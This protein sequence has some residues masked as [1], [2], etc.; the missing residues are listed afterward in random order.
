MFEEKTIEQKETTKI[1]QDWKGN[2]CEIN[3]QIPV[4]YLRDPVDFV[5]RRWIK[6]PVETRDDW[7]QMK[8]RYDPDDKAR[9][10]GDP[11]VLA[12]ELKKR[13][14]PVKLE[15]SG[16]FWMLREWLGFEKLCLM[17]YEDPGFVQDMIKFWT[18]FISKLLEN[19]FSYFV[20]DEVHIEEDMAYKG[21]SMISP[22]MVKEFF[23]PAWCQWEEIIKA[24]EVPLYG[25]DSDGF[26][27]ELIPLWIEAG[28]NF[29]DPVEVAAG[30][31]M[32]EYRKR[33]GKKMAF[34]GGIDKRAMAK[35]GKI[36]ESEFKRNLPVTK[37]G[38]FI[39][40]CDHCDN[41]IP[42]DVSW[43]NYLHYT[44]LLAKVTG[45]L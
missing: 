12:A 6:C 30:N 22:A 20:P 45:W 13:T 36:L 21:H 32:N 35:G 19:T 10:P 18:D 24:A 3:N 39:P 34:R 40:T 9:Y 14:W 28:F 33:F 23:F 25:I 4:Q 38:G 27:G 17:F 2:I 7:E 31:D 11:H 16:P 44:G 41:G 29:C 5:T 1:V 43:S 15:F 37:D 26:I 8:I 42:P